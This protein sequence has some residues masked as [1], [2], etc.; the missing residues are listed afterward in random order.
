[1]NGVEHAS[2]QAQGVM[3]SPHW[4]ILDTGL[5]DSSE[6]AKVIVLFLLVS[7][8]FEIITRLIWSPLQARTINVLLRHDQIVSAE[9][10]FVY[11]KTQ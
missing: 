7:G 1:M 8:Y 4:N 9:L 5:T 2:C 6:T 3:K 10:K 11:Q